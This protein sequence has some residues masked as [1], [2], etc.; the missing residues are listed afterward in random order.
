MQG[1]SPDLATSCP[2]DLPGACPSPA[3]SYQSDV[4]PVI[5][6]K[7]VSCHSPGGQS[8]DRP[9]QTY[10]EVF[11]LRT[12]VL[13]QVYGCLMPPVGSPQLTPSE[14]AAILGWLVCGA[15]QN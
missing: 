7:C 1:T 5:M 15:P 13:T 3:P 4:A 10:A 8:S 6:Q 14:R 11:A 2:N 12:S 9:L